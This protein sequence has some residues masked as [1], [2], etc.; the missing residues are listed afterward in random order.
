MRFLLFASG[1]VTVSAFFP[2]LETPHRTVVAVKSASSTHIKG[3]TYLLTYARTVT[4][5]RRQRNNSTGNVSPVSQSVF[6]KAVVTLH[7]AS[8]ATRAVDAQRR[9]RVTQ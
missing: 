8:T 9:S 2:G 6:V 3:L 7:C 5:L 4:Y 1:H